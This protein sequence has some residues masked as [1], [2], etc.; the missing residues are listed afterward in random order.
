MSRRHY[1]TPGR[2]SRAQPAGQTASESTSTSQEMSCEVKEYEAR[3]NWEGT[4]TVREAVPCPDADEKDE[5]K[6]ALR[7]YKY[8]NKMGGIE[9]VTLEV[10]SPRIREALR[11]VVGSYPDQNLNGPVALTGASEWQ[12]LACLFHYRNELQEYGDGLEDGVAKQHVRLVVEFIKR[13]FRREIRRLED[14][15]EL[16]DYPS[17][18]FQDLWMLFKPGDL[19]FGGQGCEQHLT[20]IVKLQHNAATETWI[21]T[22]K[23]FAYDGSRFGYIQRQIQIVSF[24]SCTELSSLPAIPLK[25][26]PDPQGLQDYL[27]TRGKKYCDLTGIKYQGYAGTVVTVDRE[28]TTNMQGRV[29]DTFPI[30]VI[31]LQGRIILDPKTFIE[32]RTDEDIKIIEQ[33]DV[34]HNPITSEEY[35]LAHFRTAGF[36]LSEK[37]WGWFHIDSIKEVD[38][39]DGAFDALMLPSKQKRLIRALTTRTISSSDGFDDLIQGKGKGCIFLLHGEPGIGK[40]FTAESIADDIKRPLYVMMSG[41]LG[42]DVKTVDQNLRKV[43]KL[44][45]AW[46]AVLLIDEA[47]VFLEKR[48]SHNLAR[49]SLVS[50]FLRTLE[51]FSGVLFLTTNRISSFD[52]A[53]QSRIHLALRYSPLT[54]SARESLW[55]LFLGRTPG[56]DAADWS[57]ET[58]KELGAVDVNGRQI[59]NTVRT[60]Y[61]LAL[62]EDAKFRM[63]QVRDVLET[64]GEFQR[65]FNRGTQRT[66][67]Q[68]VE[69][70]ETPETG[71]LDLGFTD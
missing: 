64:V 17:C 8:Y 60:A 53:F 6:F 31:K 47:D 13:E 61:A 28:R 5:G 43:L 22:V 66:G 58:L 11:K 18:E 67:W 1:S 19:V 24:E 15:L 21:I 56:Y 10:Q 71:S 2:V 9:K 62:A 7:F 45:T 49:N 30:G 29:K 54:P 50:I 4:R 32:E 63:E 34:S 69:G 52:L 59:K 37:C 44:V 68:E 65:D 42:S 39:D 35:I 12:A 3:Y 20:K 33:R 48:S 38:F 26:H 25:Y 14:N 23:A 27:L 70:M 16:G 36:S 57:E 46:K 55:R 51:Y 41:E 40:T